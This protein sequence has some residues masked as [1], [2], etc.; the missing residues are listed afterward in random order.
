MPHRSS[1]HQVMTKAIAQEVF[2]GTVGPG[3]R[4][5]HS[6]DT[7]CKHFSASR[8]IVREAIQVLADKGL[9]QLHPWIGILPR[10]RSEWNLLD[11]DLL[12]WLCEAG[13]DDLF[14]W[15]LCEVRAIV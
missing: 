2:R 10:P 5:F 1:F 6:V 12:G 13:V 8:S 11:P 4:P 14:V 7:L 3:F 9:L 15:D